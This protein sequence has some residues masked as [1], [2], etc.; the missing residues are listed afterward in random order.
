[1]STPL[2]GHFGAGG[3]VWPAVSLGVRVRGHAFVV[4]LV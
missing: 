4:G 1:M 3:A 2:T